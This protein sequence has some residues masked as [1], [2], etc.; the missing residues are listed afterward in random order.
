MSAEQMAKIYAM[1]T[2]IDTNFGRL[3]AK[4]DERK[5][6]DNTIVIFLTDNGPQ[7]G[8]YNAGMR[9]LKGTVYEGGIRV[10]FFVRWPAGG[11]GGGRKV[12]AAC[13]HI[14]VLPTLAAACGVEP[15]KDRT[16][17]GINLL[18][19]WKG[20]AKDTAERT[21]FFQWH[22]GDVPEKGRACA[23]RGKQYKL[24]HAGGQQL[25]AAPAGKWELFDLL[26]DPYEQHDLAAQKSDVVAKLKA[27]YER[28]FDDVTRRGFDPPR[29]QVG[30]PHEN[31]TRLTRQDW[32]GPRN[33]DWNGT[34]GL[35]FWLVNLPTAG[36]FDVTLRVKEVKDGST[37]RFRLGDVTAD[38][39]LAATPMRQVTF[40]GLKL[41]AGD[42]KLEAWVERGTNS[43]GVWD[44]ELTRSK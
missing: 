28:W 5:L 30:T 40:N 24:A 12:D 11:V 3:L 14:D 8:R 20:E 13:A 43:T 10:P 17:D 34:A 21:L 42:A 36:T 37:L 1:E 2:N 32:R 31:P 9:G 19:L 38:A 18:P 25:G 22:R 6:T 39:K 7:Q 33:A 16:I 29:I 15:P 26:A 44:V 41:P 4:L 35:G 27:E 23:A